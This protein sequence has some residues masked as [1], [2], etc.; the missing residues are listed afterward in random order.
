QIATWRATC[1]TAASL[2][3]AARIPRASLRLLRARGRAA[4]GMRLSTHALLSA[5]TDVTRIAPAL[6]PQTT[7]YGPESNAAVQ[8]GLGL[9]RKQLMSGATRILKRLTW[10]LSFTLN[11]DSQRPGTRTISSPGVNRRN[12]IT[13]DT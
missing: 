11:Q 9:P 1:S 12:A 13:Y 5:R 7:L 6:A 4:R 3:P 8:R 2:N 10:K